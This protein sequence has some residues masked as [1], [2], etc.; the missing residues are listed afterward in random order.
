M[1]SYNKQSISNSDINAVSKALRGEIITRGKLV[2]IF[3]KK[4]SNLVKSKYCTSFNSAS[5]ALTAACFSIGIKKND[6]VWTV[7]NSFVATAS[8][9]L[10]FSAKVDFVDIDKDYK[11]ISIFELEKKLTKAK[12]LGK[13][14]KLL[15][16]VHFAGQPPNQKKIHFLSQKYGFKIIE[17][18]SHSL[19]AKRHKEP[20]G[21]CKWSDII[22]SSFHQ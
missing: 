16:T 19:G 18:A 6:I 9:A 7:P 15:I 17:D 5:S 13:L 14:P 3:E 22:V 2:K 4:I 8:C 11:N 1:I 20:V 12:K 21:S 10:H